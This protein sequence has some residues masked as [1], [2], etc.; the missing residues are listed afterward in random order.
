[1]NEEL[2]RSVAK[3][4][5]EIDTQIERSVD[6][7]LE[8]LKLDDEKV[9]L[10][11][12]TDEHAETM[13]KL[14][15]SVVDLEGKIARGG[16]NG[17]PKQVSFQDELSK[18]IDIAFEKGEISRTRKQPLSFEIKEKAVGDFNAANFVQGLTPSFS[19]LDVRPGVISPLFDNHIRPYLP[20]TSTNK[21]A[22]Y[23]ARETGTE[24]GFAPTAMGATKPQFDLDLT[25]AQA[26]VRKI[27]GYM[28]L[29]EE[30]VDDVPYLLNYI[31]MRGL[32]EYRN[33]EDE[34]LLYGS[35]SGINLS[36]LF[37]LA[38]AFSA[39]PLR[40]PTVN[41]YD[42]LVAAKKQLRLSN[43]SPTVIFV[44]PEDYVAMRLAKSTQGQYIFPV[45]PGTDRI[46]CDGTVVVD[47][48]R[49]TAGDFLV[50]DARSCEIADR[51]GVEVR[52]FDQDRDNAIVNMVT[53][54]IEA[55]LAL[56]VYRSNAFV[57]GTFAAAKTALT[58][59]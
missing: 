38:T 53:I 31:T 41:N 33:K 7:A 8:G 15:T 51:K 40:V 6:R 10:K 26:N 54:V 17:Q 45:I 14:K 44:N 21:D 36:G 19:A 22:I 28:R 37:T 43:L 25:T 59:V 29:P 34:Q 32:E 13:A 1:M 16:M 47:N 24:G 11:K 18:H 58:P 35:G 27:A 55:R 42:V 49:I 46:T 39:G 30:M 5:T 57:K 23:Y 56:P 9:A 48:N 2:E 52:L 3:L 50:A 12:L 20:Q 4:K